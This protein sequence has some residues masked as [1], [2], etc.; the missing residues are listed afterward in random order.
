MAE[1]IKR[2][3][4]I[5]AVDS[6]IDQIQ[7]SADSPWIGLACSITLNVIKIRLYAIPTIEAKKRKKKNG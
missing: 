6:M 4:A 7:K 5:R 3:D 1:Y 2:S